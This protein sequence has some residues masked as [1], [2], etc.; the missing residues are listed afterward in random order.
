MHGTDVDFR[1]ALVN[2]DRRKI[3]QVNRTGAKAFMFALCTHDIQGNLFLAVLLILVHVY[4]LQGL[5][6]IF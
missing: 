1:F 3:V 2:D 6:Q 4:S 5:I